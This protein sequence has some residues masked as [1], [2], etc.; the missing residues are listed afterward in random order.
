M[1][2]IKAYEELRNLLN[3]AVQAGRIP[4]VD[5]PQH[6]GQQQGPRTSAPAAAPPM[7]TGLPP[8]TATPPTAP[9]W[10]PATG[11]PPAPT[12]W[13]ANSAPPLMG[14][15]QAPSASPLGGG[16]LPSA[17]ADEAAR[18]AQQLGGLPTPPPDDGSRPF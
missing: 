17:P 15:Y 11:T 16:P 9:G 14:G 18:L 5:I 2:E 12:G 13:T 4:Y 1:V 6:G 3:E 8:T 7:P 10:P